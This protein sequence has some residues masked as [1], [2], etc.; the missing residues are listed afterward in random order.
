[1]QLH[2][3]TKTR[4]PKKRIGRGGKRGTFSGRGS[5]GQK[6]RAGG[7]VRP[8]MRD[9]VKRFPKKRGYRFARTVVK[10]TEVTLTKL[11]KAYSDGDVVNILTLR[12]KK[13][14]GPTDLTAK[15]IRTGEIKK[16]L[17]ISHVQITKGAQK[18]IEKAGGDVRISPAD[19]VK[20]EK[21]AKRQAP[22]QPTKDTKSKKKAPP[23]KPAKPKAEK[24]KK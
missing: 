19:K 10:P 24:Q 21:R 22:K 5:K 2:E 15:I 6:S 11:E 7:K 18:E 14:I 4:T 8:V 23:K 12:E 13:L 1:M 20:Q 9:I 17:K 3:L 16:K